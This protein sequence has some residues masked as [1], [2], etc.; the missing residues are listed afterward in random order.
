MLFLTQ[1]IKNPIFFM[2]LILK[3]HILTIFRCSLLYL[4]YPV[5]I[6]ILL[7]IQEDS[8]YVNIFNIFVPL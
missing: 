8:Y 1:I 4:E 7:K 3:I 6:F 5:I 2:L